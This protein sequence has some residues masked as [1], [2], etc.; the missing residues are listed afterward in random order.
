MVPAL[1][2]LFALMLSGCAA[3]ADFSGDVRDARDGLADL[4]ASLADKCP[5]GQPAALCG[6]ARDFTGAAERTL[7]GATT[8]LYSGADIA[9]DLTQAWSYIQSGWAALTALMDSS[10]KASS[11]TA[12]EPL[13]FPVQNPYVEPGSAT[14]TR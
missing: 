2:A 4:S 11:V 8:G 1:A 12:A 3:F 6:V 10:T 7:N 9:K 13:P 5:K 14:V